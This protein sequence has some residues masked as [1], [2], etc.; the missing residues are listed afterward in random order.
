MDDPLSDALLHRKVPLGMVLR[1][2]LDARSGEVR[3]EALDPLEAAAR[4]AEEEEEAAAAEGAGS[5]TV[6]GHSSGFGGS[7]IVKRDDGGD[8]GNGG[9]PWEGRRDK[10]RS[11]ERVFTVVDDSQ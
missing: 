9:A 4:D 10:A 7:I 2:D 5:I 1:L 6:E 3:V 8:G 11:A